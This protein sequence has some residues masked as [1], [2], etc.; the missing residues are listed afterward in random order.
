MVGELINKFTAKDQ[1]AGYTDAGMAEMDAAHLEQRER[2]S[3]EQVREKKR[4]RCRLQTGNSTMNVN[5]N[6]KG[7]RSGNGSRNENENNCSCNKRI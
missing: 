7:R 1:Y 3:D 4:N 5:V 6:W 2:A